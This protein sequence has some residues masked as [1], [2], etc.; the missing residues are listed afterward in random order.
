M[1]FKHDWTDNITIINLSEDLPKTVHNVSWI[2]VQ[3]FYQEFV[4]VKASHVGYLMKGNKNNLV[5]F[6]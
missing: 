4:S 2:S 6:M 1:F 3:D 5:N